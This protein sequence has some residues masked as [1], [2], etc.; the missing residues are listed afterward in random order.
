MDYYTYDIDGNFKGVT[1]TEPIAVLWTKTP[2][3]ASFVAPK[4]DGEKWYESGV[5]DTAFFIAQL[6]SAFDAKFETY[7]MAKGYTDTTDLLSHAAN[8]NSV[9]HAEA[10]SLIQWSHDEW[11]AAIADIDENS[12][13]EEIIDSLQPFE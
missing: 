1:E 10:L 7:W 4:W 6:S 12:N 9:Y 13:I 8:H 5:F 11:E 2:Y 3:I